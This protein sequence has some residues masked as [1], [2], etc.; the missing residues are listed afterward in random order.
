MPKRSM[1]SRPR[2]SPESSTAFLAAATAYRMDRSKRL[3]FAGSTKRVGSNPLISQA[4]LLCIVRASKR[5]TGPAWGVPLTSESQNVS[6]GQSDGRND[7]DT[8]YRQCDGGRCCSWSAIASRGQETDERRSVRHISSVSITK[9]RNHRPFLQQN[10]DG[11]GRHE[12]KKE[13]R[14][15][16]QDWSMRM[17]PTSSRAAASRSGAS[18]RRRAPSGSADGPSSPRCASTSRPRRCAAAAG[19]QGKR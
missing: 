13:R 8:G 16:H 11:D 18:P 19:P 17:A 6:E 15:L 9:M 2:S 5:V 3:A 12:G 4:S 7:P 10:S 14:R 1:S